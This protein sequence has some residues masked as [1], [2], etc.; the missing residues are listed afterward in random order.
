MAEGRKRF[1]FIFD[2]AVFLLL[3]IAAVLMM[4]R[5]SSLQD[6]WIS[7]AS[8]RTHAFVWG[9][10]EKVQNFFS[11]DKQNRT[12]ASENIELS[13]LVREFGQRDLSY[14]ENHLYDSRIGNFRLTPATIIKA[15]RNSQHNYIVLDKGSEDG[16]KP[17]TGIVTTNGVVGIVNTVGKHFS[18]GLTLMN[19]KMSVSARIGL[20]GLVAPLE[21]D[22][23]HSDG[24]MMRGL[25]LH[26][27]I[28]PGDTVWTSGFSSVFPPDIPI[29][30]T[31][32]LRQVDGSTNEVAVKLFQDFAALRYVIITENLEREEIE[33]LEREAQR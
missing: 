25:P 30:I 13:A 22:G 3:E 4:S 28:S 21:W 14:R 9:V 27:E 1:G 23:V 11:L 16:I 10:S 33:E 12:L 18:Y 8:H 20:T 5:T 31:G 29:G 26:H 6:I 7:R 19:T 17:Q 2:A 15:S 32:K 24:A